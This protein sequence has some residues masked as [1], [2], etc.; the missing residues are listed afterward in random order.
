M[1]GRPY[2]FLERL[3]L[4]GV[5]SKRFSVSQNSE[6]FNLAMNPAHYVTMVNMEIRPNG[7]LIYFRKKL[8]NYTA[9][10]TFQELSIT[11]ERD[12]KLMT[13]TSYIVFKDAILIDPSF[14]KRLFQL[15]EK[16]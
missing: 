5:G 3:K 16:T 12:L 7:I 9:V 10:Y 15:I 14:S 2:T 8:D 1:V 13:D 6:D 11:G 4:K